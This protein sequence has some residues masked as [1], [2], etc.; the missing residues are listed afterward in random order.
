MTPYIII[1]LSR[2]HWSSYQS[3]F[4][5]ASKLL[6][7]DPKCLTINLSA[8][9]TWLAGW[10]DVMIVS[11][12]A[13][14]WQVRGGVARPHTLRVNYNYTVYYHSNYGRAITTV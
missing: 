8:S 13:L 1:A 4:G 2:V 7:Y 14:A 9:L 5:P 3:H 10:L 11:E 6:L 12:A